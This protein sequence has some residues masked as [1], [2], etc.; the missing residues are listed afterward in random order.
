VL[1]CRG[2]QQL[3]KDG[4]RCHG[5]LLALPDRTVGLHPGAVNGEIL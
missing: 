1:A 3:S 5:Y 4:R 2:I